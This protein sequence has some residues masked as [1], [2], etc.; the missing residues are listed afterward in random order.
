VTSDS[1][2]YAEHD[3]IKLTG[4]LYRPHAVD[5]APVLIAV[6]GGGWQSGSPTESYKHWAPYL[7]R[8]GY[9]VFTIRYRLSGAAGK[10]YPEAVRD[11]RASVAFVRG[12]A[13]ELG[14]DSD[15]IGMIGD[16]AGAHLAALVALAGDQPQ[17]APP[18]SSAFP[19]PLAGTVKAVIGVYGVYDLQAQWAHDQLARPRDHITEKFLGH[20]PMQDR[21][22]FF[23]ASPL[24]YA[25]TDRNQTRFLL[26]HGTHD[27]I[28]DPAT[29]S[30]AF[31][32][33]LKQAGFFVRSIV[34][35]GAGHFWIRD[36]VDEPGGY[37][38]HV[39]PTLLRFLQGAL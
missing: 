20:A 4:E 19:G 30:S 36:P 34:V 9:A 2:E 16:S 15:R 23:E 17:F 35:P 12:K 11:V 21:R 10:T 5:A 18:P 8:H 39:A 32:T 31:M 1:F 28:V 33:A 22:A 24:S 3:G 25:T 27:D 7:A 26:I 14:V 13:A 38:A 29:Q 6:H 37:G